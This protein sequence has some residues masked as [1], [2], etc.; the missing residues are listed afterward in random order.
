MFDL[1]RDRFR[2]IALDRVGYHR[3]GSL[4]RVA[5][6]EEQVEAIAAVHS[7]CTSDPS[8]VFGHAASGVF[9]VAYAVAH[10]NR[11]RGLVLMEPALLAIFPADGPRPGVATTIEMVAPLPHAGGIHQTIAEFWGIRHS[12]L[13]P[14]ALDESA[15]DV[16]VSNR[17]MWWEA[18]AM[19]CALAA[20]WAPTPSEWARLTQP[21]LVMEGDR[22]DDVLRTVAAMVS[23]L[24][25]HGELA[26]LKGH[27]HVAHWDAPDGVAQK[28]VEFIER[29]SAS[30]GE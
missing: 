27:D 20:S 16:V 12:E 5:T 26:T 13:S 23:E 6:L 10:P 2:C 8:W 24:L 29:I 11:V 18:H 4:D 19:E 1:L 30:E 21:S 14:E 25:P 9:A 7:A 3:S 28:A 22:T 17:R 15:A